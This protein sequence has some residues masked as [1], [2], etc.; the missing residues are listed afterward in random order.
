M[1]SKIIKDTDNYLDKIEKKKKYCYIN[2]GLWEYRIANFCFV[3]DMLSVIIWCVDCGCIPIVNVFPEREEKSYYSSNESLWDMFFEQPLL[4]RISSTRKY[5]ICPIIISPIRARFDDVKDKN[6][7]KFWN[8]MLNLFVRFRTDIIDYFENEYDALINGKSVV[9]CVLRS[10][11]YTKTRPKN[12]PI[13][14]TVQE[15]IN[16]LHTVIRKYDIEYIYLATE[17]Y[18]IAQLLKREFSNKVIENKRYY[19]NQQFDDEDMQRVSQVHF[20]RENDAFLR[21]LEYMSSINL[22]SKCDYLVTGLS[23]GSEMAIYRNGNHYKY[24]YI[25][26]KGVY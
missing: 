9:A 20:D 22:V 10:T 19:F 13:Q 26:D 4:E 18:N 24:S 14:P 2:K 15:T 23:G 7:I 12:H 25:F 17:D 21:M 6:K 8:K 11:D 5:K 16:K 1:E 3:K